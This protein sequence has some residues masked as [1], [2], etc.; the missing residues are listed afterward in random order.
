MLY[1]SLLDGTS[2]VCFETLYEIQG[3][4]TNNTDDQGDEQASRREVAKHEDLADEGQTVTFPRIAT[5]ASDA[6][7]GD[8]YV[9]G[10]GTVRIVDSVY[11]ENLR[12]GTEYQMSGTLHEKQSG[13]A[14]INSDGTPVSAQ[15]TFTPTEPSGTVTLEFTFDASLVQGTSIVAFETCLRD[16][17]EV[18]V[19]ADITDEDQTVHMARIGTTATNKATNTHEAEAASKVTIVD[20]VAYEGL[21][22]DTEYALVGTLYNKATGQQLQASNGDA[23]SA[24]TAFTPKEASGTAEVTFE[25]DASQLGGSTVVAFER[26]NLQGRL[27]ASHE[28]IADEAQSVLIRKPEDT[29]RND[30]G[31]KQASSSTPSSGS[32]TTTKTSTPKTG[33]AMMSPI[34]L[35]CG[36]TIAMGIGMIGTWTRR[37]H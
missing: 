35:A 6:E 1:A 25:F 21:V 11:Y 26:L 27:A 31:T 30:S 9:L 29:Q 10:T 3:N 7:D 36:G 17:M 8:S 28:D 16:G 15:T 14:I 19:H 5:K 32:T 4:E 20:R 22:P 13:N 12:P 23:V 24:R 37:K 34:L 2:V 18:A 33:D